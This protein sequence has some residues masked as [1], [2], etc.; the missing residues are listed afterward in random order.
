[1]ELSVLDTQTLE[2]VSYDKFHQNVTPKF[3]D[4][5]GREIRETF[6][7]ALLQGGCSDKQYLLKN[8]LVINE[9]SYVQLF[10]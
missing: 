10:E 8:A 1:M 3:H 9:A 2:N 5:C 4:T 7:T 6:H